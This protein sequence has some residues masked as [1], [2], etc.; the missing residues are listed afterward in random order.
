MLVNRMSR[1]ASSH[2]LAGFTLIELMVVVAMVAILAALAAPSLRQ[3]SAHQAL[4]TAVSELVS[5][6]MN[7][8]SLAI[9]R[10]APVVLEPLSGNDWT[11]GWRIY[12]E[13]DNT[14]GY[15]AGSDELVATGPSFPDSV[16]I[17]SSPPTNCTVKNRFAYQPSGFLKFGGDYGNGG[18]PLVST[19]SE[20]HRCVVFDKI[21]RTRI[22]GGSKSGNSDAGAC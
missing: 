14:E 19:E 8:R 21:G 9:S 11:S 18:V 5:A 1:P 10:N 4:S 12:L 2:P 15:A 16:A 22:C 20:R 7:A 13:K 17:N 6:A 3:F